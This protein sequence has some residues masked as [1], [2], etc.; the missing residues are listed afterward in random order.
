MLIVRLRKENT[1][2]VA[3]E[4]CTLAGLTAMLG[5]EILM[6]VRQTGTLARLIV[7]L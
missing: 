2:V 5:K 3:R 4:I 1:A 7:N 6:I